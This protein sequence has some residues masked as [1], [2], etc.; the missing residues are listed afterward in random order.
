MSNPDEYLV[1]SGFGLGF[2]ARSGQ[3]VTIV[4]LEGAQAGDFVALHQVDPR[5]G[6]S[7]VRTRR[8]LGSLFFGV[9]DTLVSDYDNPMLKVVVDTIAV[10]DSTVP[11]CDPTRYAVD[12]GVPGHRNCLE[13]LHDSLLAHQEI[14]LLDVP[15]PFNLFQNSPV[16]A[17]GRTGVINPP[18]RVGDRITFQ[19][20]MDMV[21]ALSP[22]P[23]DII[24]GNG[25]CPMDMKA[26]VSDAIP[27]T[28]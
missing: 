17:D 27:E 10:H 9:R 24:P 13:N 7:P 8:H 21:C 19:V 15:E 25:L 11:A 5:E 20:L 22:C 1:K 6:L 12:F 16:V 23:Q 3:Y 4:D 14:D 2:T 28:N 18:S 26:I